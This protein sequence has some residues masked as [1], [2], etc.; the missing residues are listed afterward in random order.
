VSRKVHT[1]HN[2]RNI[3]LHNQALLFSHFVTQSLPAA[4]YHHQCPCR[5]KCWCHPRTGRDKIK[6]CQYKVICL[7]YWWAAN[8]MPL[9]RKTKRQQTLVDYNSTHRLLSL[10]YFCTISTN[11]FA[12][13]NSHCL[14]CVKF[15]KNVWSRFKDKMWIEDAYSHKFLFC[16]LTKGIKR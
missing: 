10:N 3:T 8:E 11:T 14:P 4:A 12:Q 9:R 15:H 13:Q 7:I 16:S 1:H 5:R 6:T 2:A